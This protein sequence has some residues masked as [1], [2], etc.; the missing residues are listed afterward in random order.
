MTTLVQRMA[1]NPAKRFGVHH[2]GFLREGYRADLV[3]VDMARSTLVTPARVLSRCGW[4]PFEDR[5][6]RSYVHSTIVNGLTAYENDTV[7][8]HNAAMRLEFRGGRG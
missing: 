6:F 3:L 7:I 8:E 4:S 2:R 5:R 1:H